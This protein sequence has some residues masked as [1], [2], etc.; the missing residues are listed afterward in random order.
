MFA[1]R[2]LSSRLAPLAAAG[3]SLFVPATGSASPPGAPP[4][5][6][7]ATAGLERR[8]GL[9]PLWLDA[10]KARVLVALTQDRK[11]DCGEFLYQVHM[12]SGVG[13]TPVGIDRSNPGE[14]QVLAFRR[15]GDRLMAEFENTTFRADLGGVDEKRAVKDSFPPSIVWSGDVV[16]ESGGMVLVDLTGF[17]TRDAFGV[18]DALKRA[19]Q[20]DFAVAADRSYPDLGET[21][22]FPDNLEFEAHETFV[23]AAPGEEVKALAPNAHAVTLIEHQSLIRLPAPGFVPRLADPRTGA[24]DLLTADYGASLTEPVVRRLATR[25][26]LEKTDPAAARSPVKKPIVFYVDRAAPEPVRSALADGARWWS[27]AFD[28]AGFI[29]AF[30]VDILPEGVSPLDARYNVINWVHR[31]TRG[32]SYGYPVAD[33]RTGEIVKGAVLL[34]SLRARQDML[35]FEGLE[36]S[37]DLGKGGPNDPAILALRRLR[38]LAVHETGHALGLAHNFAASTYGDRAS[39]MDYPGPRVTVV[40][41]KLDFSDAYKMGLG[42]WDRF[43]IRWLYGS[44]PAGEPGAAALEA[45]VRDGY[46]HGLSYVRDE[47]ARPTGSAHPR[48]ALW[49]DGADPVAA[50]AQALAVRKVALERFGPRNL[51]AG[52][53]LSD[54]RRMVVPVY[55]FHRYE[56]DAVAKSIGGVDFTY[57]VLGDGSPPPRPVDGPAQRRALSA[58]LATLEPEVLDLPDT[59]IDALSAGR[60]GA[61][62]RAYEVEVF[63]DNQ[64]PIFDIATAARAAVDITLDDLLEPSRLER[65]ADQGA[66]LPDALRLGELLDRT[67]EEVFNTGSSP[68]RQARLRRVARDAL[69]VKLVALLEDPRTPAPVKTEVRG[70]LDRLSERLTRIKAGDPDDTALS[71]EII[72]M[73]KTPSLATAEVKRQSKPPPGMPIGAA[74]GD[75]GWFGDT[76]T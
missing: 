9:L 15:V 47:D 54:L 34:G 50:L 20:G 8:S 10:R 76:P 18:V 74:N 70:A 41:G 4:T 30:R 64:S 44:I 19:G 26:R 58:L 31:Q 2:A 23:S 38:Q 62:D 63:G 69:A 12:R 61:S 14:T 33:P 53:P 39:V 16:A 52:S 28:R 6:E 13:S 5:I 17:L 25:F 42:D 21:Q 67:I 37:H 59:T 57:G 68:P 75:D 48:G 27:E 45:V 72:A 36:G 71:H 35:I 65:V 1:T 73:I 66:R 29:D 40:G 43:A 32:W 22:A 56:V 60:D 55:L 3:L 51:P 46:A 24:I 49:D 7:Q 11:G